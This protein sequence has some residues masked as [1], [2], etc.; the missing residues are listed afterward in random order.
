M[1]SS[2]KASD[3][4][5]MTQS[6]AGEVKLGETM[7]VLGSID[8]LE[9]CSAQFVLLGIEEDIG[10]RANLGRS[11]CNDAWRYFLPSFVNLQDN[12][13]LYGKN[14]AILGRLA[15]ADLMQSAEKLDASRTNDLKKL[16]KL[17]A[18]IDKRVAATILAIAK[19][20]KTPIIIGGGHNNAYGILNGF[21]QA[22]NNALSVLNIDPHADYR[23]LEG[24]HSGNGFSYAHA[25]N[26]LRN[27]AVFGLHE[28]YNSAATMAHFHE[29]SDLYYL[30]FDELLT[31]STVERDRLFKDVLNWLGTDNIGLELDLDAITGFPASA[32]NA[33]GFS[34][35]QARLMIKTAAALKQPLYF[36]LA[37][38]APGLAPNNEAKVYIGKSLGY[39]V[40]DFIKSWG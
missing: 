22:R 21:F 30:S 27:Y 3:I 24:R 19:T 15:L 17:T 39:L 7:Q 23:A 25:E 18:Q 9:D 2:Y 11:G 28:S 6:R 29:R 32:L 1:L 5:N 10:V 38:A 4:L 34:I 36:H 26:S 20:G 12:G 13:F 35:Q 31:F 37:E 40:S 14:I 8:E 16:R 33:S